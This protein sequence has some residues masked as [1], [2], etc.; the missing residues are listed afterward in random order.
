MIVADPPWPMHGGGKCK[1]GVDKHYKLMSLPDIKQYLVQQGFV[2][3]KSA[4]LFLWRVTSLQREC[5]DVIDDWG[6]T[7]KTELVWVK[8]TTK[9]NRHFGMGHH[10]RAEHETCV[11]AT[12]GSPKVLVKNIRS[13]FDAK[14]GRHSEKPDE[15]F[16]IVEA[17]TGPPTPDTH[18]EL[19]SRKQRPGWTCVGDEL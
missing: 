5:Y 8:K 13:T 11:V 19:F 3:D 18:L 4:Y 6:F 17:L 15:F 7:A 12:K 10:L 16:R 1:R 9:G 2:I 14:I